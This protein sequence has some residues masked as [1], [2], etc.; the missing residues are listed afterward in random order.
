MEEAWADCVRTAL[1]RAEYWGDPE[2]L[3]GG[4]TQSPSPKETDDC[5]V[6]VWVVDGR[7]GCVR[8]RNIEQ[9][10]QRRAWDGCSGRDLGVR[11][12]LQRLGGEWVHVSTLPS[13][14]HLGLPFSL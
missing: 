6:C 13:S 9:S 10:K 1:G 3:T 8:V 11:E 7:G 12:Q 5:G 4:A 14:V 2:N